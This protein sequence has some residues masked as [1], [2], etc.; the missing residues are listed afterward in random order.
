MTNP[1]NNWPKHP[2]GRN[3]RIGEMSAADAQRVSEDAVKRLVP[4]FAAQGVALKFRRPEIVLYRDGG[5]WAATHRGIERKDDH[6]V[7]TQYSAR[8]QAMDVARMIARANP[9][10]QIGIKSSVL[11]PNCAIIYGEI[12]WLKPDFEGRS[13]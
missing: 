5:N 3:M 4:E 7:T 10:S 8:E 9:G 2:D 11:G 13:Q 1:Q 6:T 12:V